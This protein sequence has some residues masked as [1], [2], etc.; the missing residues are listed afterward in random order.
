MSVDASA[1]SGGNCAV[2]DQRCPEGQVVNGVNA[3]GTLECV[4]QARLRQQTCSGRLVVSGIR[5]D[6]TVM[7]SDPATV[8]SCGPGEVMTGVGDTG[9]PLCTTIDALV[10]E[11]VNSRCYVYFGWRDSCDGCTDPPGK[12]GRVRGD[13]MGCS[14]SGDD[15]GCAAFDLFGQRV[16]MVGVNTDGDV[17][18]DDKFWIGLKCE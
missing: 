16:E 13:A 8:V 2:G 10:R 14:A 6:G 7:C 5:A 3:D 9:E 11:Y 12:V 15:G 1:C 17:N 4:E 18:G